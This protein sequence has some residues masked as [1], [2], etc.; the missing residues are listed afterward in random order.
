M[1]PTVSFE[2]LPKD[3]RRVY[4]LLYYGHRDHSSGKRSFEFHTSKASAK[5]SG[6]AMCKAL[7]K[8]SSPI[9]W[10]DAIWIDRNQ[11]DPIRGCVVFGKYA[12]EYPTNRNA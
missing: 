5:K 9:H 11:W 4:W 2:G 8:D 1:K 3:G 12:L 6:E 10:P 7:H